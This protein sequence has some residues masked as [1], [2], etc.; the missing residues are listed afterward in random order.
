[1]TGTCH[2]KADNY[3]EN[4]GRGG[5]PAGGHAGAPSR[6]DEIPDYFAFSGGWRQA[7]K[8]FPHIQA[9]DVERVALAI[10]RRGLI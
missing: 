4:A 10:A 7:G 9:L 3:A 1:L 2:I 8:T 6:G 5:K